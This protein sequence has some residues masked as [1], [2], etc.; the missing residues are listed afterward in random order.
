MQVHTDKL[1]TRIQF[2]HRGLLRRNNVSTPSM[3]ARNGHEER[4]PR[5]F[6]TS[7]VLVSRSHG[8]AFQQLRRELRLERRTSL[9]VND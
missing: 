5:S 8:F 9:A 1:P 7:E 4:R 2:T 3:R 6:I